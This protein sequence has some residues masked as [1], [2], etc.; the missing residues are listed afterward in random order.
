MSAPQDSAT[1][2][3]KALRERY[4][5]ELAEQEKRMAALRAKVQVLDEVLAD[6]MN[7]QAIIPATVNGGDTIPS[8][9]TEAI[10]WAVNKHGR[11][12]PIPTGVVRQH[13]QA[14]GFVP[15][16]KNYSGT[17]LTTLKRLVED[18][19]ISGEKINGNWVYRSRL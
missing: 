8:G 17:M 19:R 11:G 5:S 3:I 9:L 1:R 14:A 7:G 13:M 2:S 4:A 10:I 16:G 6:Q 15:K 18:G 12:A